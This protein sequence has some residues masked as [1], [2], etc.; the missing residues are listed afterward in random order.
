MAQVK[1]K[2]SDFWSLARLQPWIFSLNNWC[3]QEV[4]LSLLCSTTGC[5][6]LCCNIALSLCNSMALVSETQ[7]SRQNPWFRLYCFSLTES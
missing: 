7:S 5:M 6:L 2:K 4:E 3:T 1:E